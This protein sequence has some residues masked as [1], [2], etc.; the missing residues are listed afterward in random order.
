[1][2][3]A[4]LI[5]LVILAFAAVILFP[6]YVLSRLGQLNEEISELKRQLA[7]RTVADERPK[8]ERFAQV[9][10][11]LQPPQP[12]SPQPPVPPP[13][14]VIE[15]PQEPTVP[16]AFIPPPPPTVIPAQPVKPSPQRRPAGLP[17]SPPPAAAPA[18]ALPPP[19]L[20]SL[21]GA[22][23]LSKV[24]IAAIAIAAAFFLQYA[25]HEGWIG[26]AAQVVIGIAAALI[27]FGLG[28][29]LLKKVVYRA[30]AQVL[31]SG[32]IIVFFLSIYAGYGYYHLPWLAFPV[33][34][35]VLALAALMASAMAAKNNT[36]AVA[37]LCL[38]GAFATPLL[39]RQ[40]GSASGDLFRLYAYLA[41]LNIWSAL[42][43]KYR[44][45]HSL[46]A[47][48]FG[49]TWLLFF[50]AGRLQ[51]PNHL[52]TEGFATAFLA[53]ACYGGI[54]NLQTQKGPE[55]AAAGME[56]R[57]GMLLLGCLAF[58][59]S[60]A[61]ILTGVK[62]FGLP[63]F[64][65][66]GVIV[67]LLL[68]GLGAAFPGEAAKLATIRQVFQYLS[69]AGLVLL[70]GITV[71][72]APP[73]TAAQVPVA[74]CFSLLVY[75]I[76][77]GV[78]VKMQ[79]ASELENPAIFLIAANALTHLM[80]AF[81][82]L[83]LIR[84]WDVNAAALWLPLAGLITFAFLLLAVRQKKQN[85]NFLAALM[86]AGLM[87]SLAAL[88]GLNLPSHGLS[89]VRG[90][91]L[92]LLEFLLVSATWIGLRR[93]TR[94]PGF[95]GDI[96]G[97]LGN[98][99][100]FFLLPASVM[101]MQEYKGFV[102]L[103][104][105]A[106]VL[107]LYHAL[108]FGAVLRRADDDSLYRFIHLGLALAFVTIAVP[109]QL[110]GSYITLAWSIESALLVWAGAAFNDKRL[111][112]YGVAVLALAA[113]KAFFLDMITEPEAFRFML[114]TR[115]LAGA[116]VIAAAYV[117]AGLL[118]RKPKLLSEAEAHVPATALFL[119]SLYTLIFISLELW[120]YFDRRLPASGRFSAQLASFSVFWCCYALALLV[121][122]LRKSAAWMRWLGA[123][124]LALAALKSLFIDIFVNP[125]PFR[126]LLNARMLSGAAVIIFAYLAA[127]LIWQRRGR[128]SKQ[129]NYLPAMAA[130][131]ASLFMLIYV[132]LDIW[133]YL[134]G[135]WEAATRSSAQQ[136]ALSI[137]WLLY[138]LTAI[139]AGIWKRIRMI[140]L[141]A[142]GLL[143][144]SI[145][146][147]FLF[148]LRF[149]EQPYRIVSFFGLGVILL[150]VSLL[151]TR[152]EERLK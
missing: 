57:V 30:Y 18:P 41:G 13:M 42:L 65:I 106:L 138:A 31:A 124:L 27:M 63:A 136:L 143:Y 149:L 117:C 10:K 21:L 73:I 22:N 101:G 102:I 109:L 4:G 123:V 60:S 100:I 115:M 72:A 90:S 81:H 8:T 7:Q 61:L 98:A 110:K 118:R 130:F 19:N 12:V 50:G 125:V 29:Y 43:V 145:I 1:M 131:V 147:V 26:P 23:W 34:F 96:V 135:S 94:L 67:A 56:W 32:G 15:K 121:L 128:L 54:T 84:L 45:W 88:F 9:L 134:D 35:A 93:R 46:T 151:Y 99:A 36:Q 64:G 75:L 14:P 127:W 86:L 137:F 105:Y 71:V 83:S 112:W 2:E 33:A 108:I 107:A 133:Q 6:I 37:A 148:D 69:A 141:F 24:G 74:A 68:S 144:L 140:R 70:M 119:A 39:I 85:S 152:F 92:F 66:I 5:L 38:A 52:L 114:N 17:P 76:F 16:A 142:M 113:A 122:G 11:D 95:R 104:G 20:E 91:I 59:I 132:S 139:L 62:A 44:P 150:V 89:P 55:E 80:V 120:D 28:Q 103:C 126:L 48:S 47:L 129:E 51:G 87:L 78:A 77:L 111:R 146:K 53:F 49:F 40:S 3:D 97:A 82:V 79:R 58:I 25:F 116:S